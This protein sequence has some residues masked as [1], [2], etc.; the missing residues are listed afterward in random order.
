M[1]FFKIYVWMQV[2]N[3]YM[4]AFTSAH[5]CIQMHMQHAKV[6]AKDQV[7]NVLVTNFIFWHSLPYFFDAGPFP[8]SEAFAV[9]LN[10]NPQARATL[11]S[12]PPLSCCPTARAN[13][14]GM[15][16]IKCKLLQDIGMWTGPPW[17]CIK[18]CQPLSQLSKLPMHL[19]LIFKHI[20]KSIS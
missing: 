8:E 18:H 13:V 7:P 11:M 3:V 14:E 5:V 6:T 16:K 20:H 19:K 12:L 10:V 1:W 4:C 15:D 2:V 9:W 17:S